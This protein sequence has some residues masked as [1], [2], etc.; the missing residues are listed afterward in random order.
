ME[1]A[2]RAGYVAMGVSFGIVGVLAMR[3]AVNGGDRTPDRQGALAVVA[4]KPFGKVLLVLLAIGFAGYALWRFVQAALDRDDE[5]E[6]A[7]GIAKRLAQ[8]ARGILYAGLCVFTVSIL[9]GSRGG[10]SGRQQE[11][12]ARAMEHGI[13]RLA[14]GAA[15][16]AL[17]GA[18]A[19]NAYR[20]L[21][22][23]FEEK[24]RM[25]EMSATERRWASRIGVAG[26]L[27]R[28]VLFA[29][30]GVFV[31]KAALEFDPAD[32]IGLDGALAKLAQQ[33]YGSWLLGTVAAG[34]V[35]YAVLCVVEARYR[36][37]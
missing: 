24:L 15:G 26:L 35:A 5:G 32:S 31:L 20:G 9:T 12:T 16:L 21:T 11:L 2:G 29:L 23:K 27:T 18:G 28:G 19:W 17:I 10:S 1:R 25:H 30:I 37:I 13:G 14:V 33:D 36:S 34:L 4:E 7:K 3:V 6:D 22:R 8:L